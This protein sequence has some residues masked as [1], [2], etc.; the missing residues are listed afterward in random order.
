MSDKEI[1]LINDLAKEQLKKGVSRQE[2]LDFL[3]KIGVRTPTGR[4]TKPYK[5]LGKVVKS[6]E[7]MTSGQI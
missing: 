6:R 3:I 7:C 5:N 2:A 1:K 4:F